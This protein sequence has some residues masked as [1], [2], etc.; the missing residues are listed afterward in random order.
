MADLRFYFCRSAGGLKK[1]EYEIS[2]SDLVR[3]A[4]SGV[5][6]LYILLYVWF[7][8]EKKRSLEIEKSLKN[9]LCKLGVISYFG[10]AF[11]RSM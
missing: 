3:A 5:Q 9:H 7:I 8:Y 2:A 11:L 1:S 10:R 4:V 6:Y